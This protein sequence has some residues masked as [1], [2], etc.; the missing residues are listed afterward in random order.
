MVNV[1]NE[2]AERVTNESRSGIFP[3]CVFCHHYFRSYW[4]LK[5]KTSCSFETSSSCYS[6]T[7]RH[8]PEERNPHVSPL[9]ICRKDINKEN[10]PEIM[11]RFVHLGKGLWRSVKMEIFVKTQRLV[12]LEREVQ[13]LRMIWAIVCS[14][15]I[16][17]RRGYEPL[18]LPLPLRM[19]VESITTSDT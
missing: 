12:F 6:V 4:H 5:M 10:W 16:P 3:S 1:G 17:L 15:Y 8:M 13:K 2:R 19:E 7:Q 11:I 14:S 9:R 18:L